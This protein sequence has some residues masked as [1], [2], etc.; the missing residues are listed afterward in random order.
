MHGRKIY[1][2]SWEFHVTSPT[3]K[4]HGEKLPV[5]PHFCDSLLRAYLTINKFDVIITKVYLNF[6]TRSDKDNLDFPGYNPVGVDL[7]IMHLF[8]ELSIFYRK[9]YSIWNHVNFKQN[10]KQS[11]AKSNFLMN[12]YM[13]SKTKHNLKKSLE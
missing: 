10:I 9:R 12:C 4:L 11:T 2:K 3:R 6:S 5:Y 8:Q 7:K 1:L 13:S